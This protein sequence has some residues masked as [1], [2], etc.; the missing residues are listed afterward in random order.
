M[1]FLIDEN[2]PNAAELLGPHG[3]V[4]TFTGR[5]PPANQL[6]NAD[7]LFIRSVTPVD[8]ALLA[9]APCLKMIGTATI[10]MEHVDQAALSERGVFFTS[11]PGSNACSVGEYVLTAVLTV[12]QEQ[13]IE[14]ARKEALIIGAGHTGSQVMKR[15]QALGMQVSVIDPLRQQVGDELPY[16]DWAELGRF[17]LVSCHV[18]FVS[19]G[20]HSTH[21][22]LNAERLKALKTN[23][24]LVNA[25]RGAVVDNQA[26]LHRLTDGASLQVVL[27]VW[28]GEPS[29]LAPLVPKVAIATPHIAGH[30]I[31]GKLR[32]VYH[33]YAAAY[34]YFNWQTKKQDELSIL[35][36][37][38]EKM[39]QVEGI[40]GQADIAQLCQSVYPVRSDDHDFRMDG[41]T[42]DGFDRL[43]RNYPLRREFSSLA[44]R[45]PSGLHARILDL[46]FVP[47]ELS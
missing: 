8:R 9:Q 31:E 4:S 28:E 47:V 35:P 1:H 22:L 13:G 42:P 26:L 32:G 43:R 7:V 23:C 18:P 17:D 40:L 44:V 11:A 12:A 10:G 29:I 27:D 3:E 20:R 14:L 25:S 41:L 19:T 16:V 5:M 38:A 39:V 45:A 21:H 24:L 34:E 36:A 33:L 6:A 30:S 15:L 2:L 37:R 46:G